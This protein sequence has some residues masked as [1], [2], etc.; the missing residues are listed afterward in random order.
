MSRYGGLLRPHD[1]DTVKGWWYSTTDRERAFAAQYLGIND[2]DGA[3]WAMVSAC[4]HSVAR[5]ALYQLQTCWAST[6]ITA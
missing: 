6:V 1:N 3:P 2:A 5:I 4:A